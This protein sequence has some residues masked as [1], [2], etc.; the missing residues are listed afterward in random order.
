MQFYLQASIVEKGITVRQYRLSRWD[1]I[2]GC[3]VTDIVA[4]FIVVACAATL[5]PNGIRDITD[6][7]EAAIALKPLAG[8]FAALMFAVGLVNAALLSAAILPLA[9]TYNICEG[10]GFESGLNKR[11]S[12]APVFYSIYTV[13]IVLGAAIVLIPR[14]PLIKLMIL[15]QVANGVLLPFVLFYMLK[16]VNRTD[17]MGKHKNSRLANAIAVTTSVAMVVL[18]VAM[19]WTTLRGG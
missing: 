1:V 16:L 9:T 4:F 3:L 5:H 13:L 12:E 10:L 6:A 19:V 7:A 2:V 8:Q 14:M 17:L 11:F 15:S 18:T